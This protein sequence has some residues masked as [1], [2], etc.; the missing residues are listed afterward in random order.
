[1]GG[2][3]ARH[4]SRGISHDVAIAVNIGNE[5]QAEIQFVTGCF[6]LLRR[7]FAPPVEKRK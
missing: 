7:R 3:E 6:H 4:I 2:S 1:M 5:G